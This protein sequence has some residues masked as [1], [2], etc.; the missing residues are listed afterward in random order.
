MLNLSNS[1]TPAFDDVS[2]PFNGSNR[3]TDNAAA[4]TDQPTDK[5]D[6]NT[7]N[8]RPDQT[9]S[10]MNVGDRHDNRVS[11]QEKV[12]AD[13]EASVASIPTEMGDDVQP[14]QNTSTF[15]TGLGRLDG[16]WTWKTTLN[17]N[18]KELSTKGFLRADTHHQRDILGR[19]ERDPVDRTR[20]RHDGRQKDANT[21]QSP[22][23]FNVPRPAP[24][25]APE[26]EPVPELAPEPVPAF[27][28]IPDAEATSGTDAAS[29][30][31]HES[32]PESSPLPEPDSEPTPNKPLPDKALMM[33]NPVGLEI[34]DFVDEL[35]GLDSDVPL[36][37][38]DLDV[39]LHSILDEISPI[40][41]DDDLLKNM[42]VESSVGDDPESRQESQ[43]G[44]NIAFYRLFDDVSSDVSRQDV[45]PEIDAIQAIADS[46]SHGTELAIATLDIT[47]PIVDTHSTYAS[48]PATTPHSQLEHP[49][50]TSLSHQFDQ[51]V[52]HFDGNNRDRD[53]IAAMPIAA[54]LINAAGLKEKSTFFYNNNI[55][56]PSV[57][58][59]VRNMRTSA[60]FA[61]N[62]GIQTYDY[63]VGLD[64]ITQTLVSIFN[65]GQRILVLEGGRMEMTYRALE[66]TDLANLYNITLLSHS[67]FNE[68]YNAGGTRRWS[69]LK[70]RFP[71]V[72]FLEIRDQNMGFC[73]TQWHWLDDADNV[74]LQQAR[75]LMKNAN[76]AS[77]AP[78]DAGMHFYILTGNERATPLDAKAFFEQ[79][80]P[81]LVSSPTV[82]PAPIPDPEIAPPPHSEIEPEPAVPDMK[83]DSLDPV[84]SLHS[85]ENGITETDSPDPEE[86]LNANR[87]GMSENPTIG[88]DDLG[89]QAWWT[90][91]VGAVFNAFSH[92]QDTYPSQVSFTHVSVPGISQE[93]LSELSQLQAQDLDTIPV[94]E[95][96]VDTMPPSIAT[97]S[98]KNLS[99]LKSPDDSKQDQA[100]QRQEED[101]VSKKVDKDKVA[102]APSI[103]AEVLRFG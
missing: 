85:N 96:P 81:S 26:P 2:L 97:P 78:S 6:I 79:Y 34:D 36:D 29:T 94:G 16:G 46:G 103:T 10:S 92:P 13:D 43:G 74:V 56:Q 8:S 61:E 99:V 57:P 86:T 100:L 65:S 67:K 9:Q 77:D 55:G 66:Q 19:S 25:A 63:E 98:E 87:N 62:L 14:V 47:L 71:I 48:D 20:F 60:A 4:L 22:L 44:D 102:I 64:E 80:P 15:F 42:N 58:D 24:D 93:S 39:E 84:D 49:L 76:T 18:P 54:A 1:F 95:L 17:A 30:P 53:D 41:L 5:T 50:P 89:Q 59:F 11:E 72:R 90:V 32:I 33:G 21:P 23:K 88:Q 38:N 40:D 51:I 91:P 27:E 68:D 101:T 3:Q 35:E 28:N 69:D 31:S 45:S 82:S 37:L 7:S 12:R 83:P 75:T 73:N 70:R 52:S